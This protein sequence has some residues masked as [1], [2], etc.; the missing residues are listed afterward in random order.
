MSILFDTSVF[1]K[2]IIKVV[3]IVIDKK[4]AD[5]STC[6]TDVILTVRTL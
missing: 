1:I 2:E 3:E 5:N 4:I 6:S